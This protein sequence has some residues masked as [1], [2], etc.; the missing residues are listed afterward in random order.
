[1]TRKNRGRTEPR[2]PGSDPN[3]DPGSAGLLQLPQQRAGVFD[4][5]AFA[6]IVEIR[7]HARSTARANTLRPHAKLFTSVVVAIP[8][9]G[10]VE[11]D[12]HIVGC[13]HELVG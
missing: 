6:V 4:R 1:M 9:L 7:P 11:A 2:T 13:F 8:A 5:V 12:V 10:A 3:Q